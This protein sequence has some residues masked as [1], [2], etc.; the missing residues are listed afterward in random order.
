MKI[1]GMISL[2]ILMVIL[3][4]AVSWGLTLGIY[5]LIT[6]CFGIGFSWKIGT[7]IWLIMCLIGGICTSR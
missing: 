1:F 4:F 2:M 6:L 5:Y 3:A 7:G